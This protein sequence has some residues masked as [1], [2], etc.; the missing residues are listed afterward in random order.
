MK[1]RR[2]LVHTPVLLGGACLAAHG[3]LATAHGTAPTGKPTAGQRIE[4]VRTYLTANE[5]DEGC[6]TWPMMPVGDTLHLVR[7][8]HSRFDPLTVRLYWRG[9]RV[10]QLTRVDN[11]IV[12]HLMDTGHRV[13]ARLDERNPQRPWAPNDITLWLCL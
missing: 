2:F 3:P 8:P 6:W 13:E 4:L 12:A 1:R 9:H 10:G 5:W 11:S 7:D